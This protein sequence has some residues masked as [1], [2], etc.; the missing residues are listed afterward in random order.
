MPV[1]RIGTSRPNP[2]SRIPELRYAHLRRCQMSEPRSLETIEK[3]L[4]D[5]SPGEKAHLLQTVARQLGGAV[6]GIDTTSGVCGGD[7]CIA[8]TR[9]PVWL[10]VRARRLG[11]SEAAL[12]HA[13][14]ALRAEDLVNAWAY[15]HLHE[16][17]IGDL[18][19]AHEAA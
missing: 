18:I 11:T 4:S 7:A 5:L 17:E 16:A 13:Y 1:A 2:E 6:P 8:R 12:L 14:P 9:I 3:T 19:E 15:A 10:L